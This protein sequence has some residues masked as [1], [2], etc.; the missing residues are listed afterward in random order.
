MS[1][2][3]KSLINVIWITRISDEEDGWLHENLSRLDR[4]FAVTIVGHT[5]L[6][7]DYYNFNYIP[8]YENGIDQQGLICHKKNLGVLASKSTYCLVLHADATPDSSFYHNAVQ[9]NYDDNTAV[10]PL[11]RYGEHRALCWGDVQSLTHPT[12]R[13]KDM[14]EAA[15]DYTYIS[16]IAIFGRKEL[17]LRFP[18]DERLRHNQG[19]DW[20]LSIRLMKNRVR[21]VGD[22]DL[23]FHA[24]RHQ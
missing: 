19:E 8:F 10:A 21:L 23:V 5:H 13:H 2:H 18:W 15:N 1:D 16:G 24:R 6:R 11:G 14:D 9:K 17:F 3:D 20:E 12:P 4:R 22:K 7:P